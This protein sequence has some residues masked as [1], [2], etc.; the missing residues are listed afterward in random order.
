MRIN[1]V[2]VAAGE[3]KRMG[4]GAPKP[5]LA[6]G[7]RPVILHTLAAFAASRA[8]KAVIVVSEKERA[9][10]EALLRGSDLGR[11]EW[12]LQSGAARRQDS[13]AR[14]LELLD[15]DCEL[16]VVHDAVRPL[17][18]AA[19][20]DRCIAAAAKDGAAVAGVPVADT[21]KIVSS[22]RRIEATPLRESL[23]AIQTPQVFGVELLREAHRKAKVES[24]EATDD[25]MLVERLGR[26]VVVVEGERR[27][28]KIT[29]PEDLAL[30]EALL[31]QSPGKS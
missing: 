30:A 20:I 2:I 5:L 1:A 9:R 26:K 24:V 15:G 14:G 27:N 8:G 7:G 3:G 11:L 13:V 18:S 10:F 19:L 12:Q 4:A 22:D 16:V 6:L 31:L 21:I 28:I 29:T 25:A 23:W 17:V